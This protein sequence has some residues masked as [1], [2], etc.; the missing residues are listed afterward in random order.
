MKK[1]F[2]ILCSGLFFVAGCGQTSTSTQNLPVLDASSPEKLIESLKTVSASVPAAQKKKF[3]AYV[4]FYTNYQLPSP[5]S[6]ERLASQLDGKNY[7]EALAVLKEDLVGLKED[8]EG[9]I[10]R[11]ALAGVPEIASQPSELTKIEITNLK[12]N[13]ETHVK[14]M[15]IKNGTNKEISALQV[16]AREDFEPGPNKRMAMFL[17]DFEPL[18]PGKKVHASE[19]EE[20]EPLQEM[21]AVKITANMPVVAIQAF[22]KDKMLVLNNEELF[23]AMDALGK[24]RTLVD[25]MDQLL[26]L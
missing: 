15:D 19:V 23:K 9:S 11:L 10:S 7:Q 5:R 12:Y 3:D 6:Y 21:L 14:E 26:Q 13:K 20:I 2:F 17:I 8:F 25:E 24:L 16:M 4:D 22:D 1:L 18:A